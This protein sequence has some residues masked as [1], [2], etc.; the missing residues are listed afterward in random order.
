MNIASTNALPVKVFLTTIP[1]SRFV[2]KKDQ[3]MHDSEGLENQ[4]FFFINKDCR[5]THRLVI[6]SKA[7]ADKSFGWY[8][9]YWA[10]N[11]LLMPLLSAVTASS[12][13]YPHMS[14][15]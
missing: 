7:L 1:K 6:S 11:F 8:L 10:A 5:M 9:E 13:F 4:P 3:I 2:K 14:G 12:T 15:P